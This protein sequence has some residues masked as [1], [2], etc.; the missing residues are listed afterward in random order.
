MIR[1]IATM[2]AL[3][4]A[5][6]VTTEAVDVRGRGEIDLAPFNCTD[7]PRS[8]VVQRVCYDEARRHLLVNVS[9]AYSEYCRLPAA[10]FAALIVAPSMGQY[11]RQNIAAATARFDCDGAN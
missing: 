11:L 2:L 8:T 9:G 10:T 5:S 1:A 4:C 6:P 7:T 3:L